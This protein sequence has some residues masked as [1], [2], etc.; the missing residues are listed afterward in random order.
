MTFTVYKKSWI[1]IKIFMKI[2][3]V[4]VKYKLCQI[5]CSNC[6]NKKYMRII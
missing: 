4:I 2:L 6:L 1:Y 5:Y 3:N